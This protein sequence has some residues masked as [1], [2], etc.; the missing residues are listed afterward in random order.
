MADLGGRGFTPPYGP[1]GI[2]PTARMHCIVEPSCSICFIVNA[3]SVLAD[4]R[5]GVVRIDVVAAAIEANELPVQYCCDARKARGYS[6][7]PKDT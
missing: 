5:Q 2:S 3:V 7:L 1:D 6:R 4:L